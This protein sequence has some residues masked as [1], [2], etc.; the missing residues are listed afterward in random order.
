MS[1]ICYMSKREAKIFP[2][3]QAVLSALGERI[4]LARKR[5]KM[6]AITLAARAG[7]SR[8]TLNRVEAGSPKVAMG[9]FFR[10]LSALHLAEGFDL[11]ANDDR[12]GHE[13][14]DLELRTSKNAL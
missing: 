11:L 12:L 4:Y 7:I 9:I 10:V 8:T 3:E 14:R 2:R 5:R 13:L 6:T 1:T